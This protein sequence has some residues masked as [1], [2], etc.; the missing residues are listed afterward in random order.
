MTQLQNESNILDDKIRAPLILEIKGN[1]LDDGPGI[2]TVVFF[3][4]CP[5]SCV[6]CHNPE[7]KHPGLEISFDEK[8]CIGCDACIEHC[9]RKAL[10]RT[11]P[12]FIDRRL[13]NLCLDCTDACP[14]G[15]LS[16]VGIEMSVD[17]IVNKVLADKPFFDNSGGGVTLS[18]GEPALFMD[19]TATLLKKLKN[20]GV[21]T[22]METCGLFNFDAFAESVLPY[23]DVIYFDIKIFDA[24]DHHRYCGIPNT[25]ILKNFERLLA[26]TSKHNKTVLPRMPLIPGITDTDANIRAIALYLKG[27]GV[28]RADILS[29]NPL[30]FE[31]CNKIG[32][33][34]PF[35][36]DNAKKTWISKERMKRAKELFFEHG[37]C[38]A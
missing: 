1:S 11:N 12:H 5:L 4:G 19:F 37:I 7:S 2:R 18:G 10:S 31:K 35:Q 6:W 29:Y 20:A 33:D 17:D 14:S 16:R 23:V 8:A 32:L 13:C 34:A 26:E 30:W 38:M 21:H 22:L 9:K 27:H 24:D 15:A 28:Q 36:T 25:Q 3:K